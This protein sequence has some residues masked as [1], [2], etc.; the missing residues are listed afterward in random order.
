MILHASIQDGGSNGTASGARN[1][2]ALSNYT[3]YFRSGDLIDFL[4]GEGFQCTEC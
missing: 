1:D 4:P 3:D 2:E